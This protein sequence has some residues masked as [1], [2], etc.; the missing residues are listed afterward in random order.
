MSISLMNLS[1]TPLSL[2]DF[3]KLLAGVSQ[4]LKNSELKQ[5]PFSCVNPLTGA[6]SVLC[7][8]NVEDLAELLAVVTGL[9][10]LDK[11]KV[12]L[13]ELQAL[14]LSSADFDAQLRGLE[15]GWL[16][17]SVARK[18]DGSVEVDQESKLPRVQIDTAKL[19]AVLQSGL[20]RTL[21]EGL[22]F[23]ADSGVNSLAEVLSSRA[24]HLVKLAVDSGASRP[25]VKG[26]YFKVSQVA[27][28]DEF[29]GSVSEQDYRVPGTPALTCNAAYQSK[30][31]L[32]LT[33]VRYQNSEGRLADLLNANALLRGQVQ[34]V[35]AT[36]TQLS[37]LDAIFDVLATFT[38]GTFS[39]EPQLFC[40]DG[41]DISAVALL[42]PMALPQE[43]LRA[44]SA[45]K[46]AHEQDLQLTTDAAQ[47]EQDTAEA[48]VQQ[49]K[50]VAPKDYPQGKAAHAAALKTAKQALADAKAQARKAG[51]G[52]LSIPSFT[53]PV[54]GAN[55]RNLASGLTTAVH[56]AAVFTAVRERAP[57]AAIGSKVYYPASLV[58]TPDIQLTKVP[59]VLGANPTG[60]ASRRSRAALFSAW[61]LEALA[62][63]MSL[64]EAWNQGDAQNRDAL[65]AAALAT[66]AARTDAKAMFVKGSA[67]TGVAAQT[68]FS[69]LVDE[70]SVSIKDGLRRAFKN[71]SF[72]A[73]DAE[74][75]AAVTS[76]V[77]MERA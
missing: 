28:G 70:V 35:M 36:W 60:A 37:G 32:A 48:A 7:A 45:L 30:D 66:L 18:A 13:K 1:A 76:V 14:Q 43:L 64:R 2:R 24:T 15:Q 75:R 73:F 26:G 77:L 25:D 12:V 51:K 19:G 39:G 59:A 57:R 68:A 21:L 40:G 74:L 27:T 52:F 44:K 31:W 17:Q 49:L 54:G 38:P 67:A 55:P 6:P 63:L 41:D 4:P 53:L 29:L 3:G 47:A 16:V 5:L 8:A 58:A 62:P 61:A 11:K 50:D 10:F 46:A 56:G 33:I 22:D 9:S 69:S 20:A 71:E 65:E 42:M 72:G 34:A 23:T